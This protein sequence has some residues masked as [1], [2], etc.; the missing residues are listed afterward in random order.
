MKIKKIVKGFFQLF[1][2]DIV[3][4]FPTVSN[5]FDVLPLLVNSH[6]CSGKDFFF[7]QIG[8]NDGKFCDPIRDLV[9]QHDLRGLLI[10]PLPDVFKLLKQNYENSTR[11]I[12]ENVA[13]SDK[14]GTFPFFRVIDESSGP[15]WWK[16]VA[17]FDKN[18]LIKLGVPLQNIKGCNVKAV[19]LKQLVEKYDL[20]EISLL[21]IDAEGY[22]Y[23]ILKS[24]MADGIKPRTINY[25]HSHLSQ[26]EKFGC[27]KLLDEHGYKFLEIETNTIALLSDLGD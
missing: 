26:N 18:H 6:I 7:I 22:D 1:G 11:L 25:E 15:S 10:E 4:F 5:P 19:T 21:Q 24:V 17:S 8:A 9:V 2:Y 3:R 20:N 12:F 13:I 27:K 14:P 23:Q 16:G